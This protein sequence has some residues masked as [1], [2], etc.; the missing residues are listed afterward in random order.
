MDYYKYKIV[1]SEELSEILIALMAEVPFDTFLENEQ[2]FEAYIPVNEPEEPVQKI[3]ADLKEKFSF[4]Y[5]KEFIKA[6]NWNAKWESNFKPIQVG[7]FCGIRADFHPPFENVQHEITINPK[8]A[9][10]T[11]HHATTF[12]VIEIMDDIPFI[13]KKVL[14]YGC[15][16]GILAVLASKLGANPI[17]AVDIEEPSFEN[18]IENCEINNVNN[19]QT[20]LGSLEKIVEGSYDIILANINRNVILQSLETLYEKLLLGGILVISGFVSEDRELMVNACEKT[21]FKIKKIKERNNW[22]CFQLKK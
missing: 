4:R 6:Q 2:G 5:E 22:L 12:L 14:D 16:T 13:K 7:K 9:F 19:V 15:G 10:G 18:T 21:G 3:L 20:Y 17:D 1:C 11:G 8:M